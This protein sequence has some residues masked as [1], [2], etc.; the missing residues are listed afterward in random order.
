[1]AAVLLAAGFY[2]S[3]ALPLKAAPVVSAAAGQPQS[4]QAPPRDRRPAEAGPETGRERELKTAIASNSGTPSQYLELSTL[5]ESRGALSEAEA[6][7]ITATK[8]P[9]GRYAQTMLAAFYNRTGR[10]DQAIATLE[11]MA[12]ASPSTPQVYQII[13]T[14]YWEKA[15][16]D[17]SLNDAQ[18]R[19]YIDAGIDATDRALAAQDN[20]VDAMVYKNIL[21]RQKAL[22]ETDATSR[23]ALLTQADAL[24]TRAMELQKQRG[25]PTMAFSPAMDRGKLPPPPPPPPPPGMEGTAP[26]RVGGNIKPPTKIRDVKPIYPPIAIASRVQGVVIMEATIDTQG[27]IADAKVI[28][29]VPLLDEAALDAVRQWQFAPTMLNGAPV[30]VTMVMTVNFTLPPQ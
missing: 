23:Q 30:P 20:Y 22:M 25:E 3:S 16:K 29:S 11:E 10:F 14:F 15:S 6:T 18:K 24:R 26:L 4:A 28:R 19:A 7:L 5:Q 13:A 9:I 17:P 21:L 27:F 8:S 2:V 1:M 12:A